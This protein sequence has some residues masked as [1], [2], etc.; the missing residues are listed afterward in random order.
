MTLQQA[1]FFG[2]LI[3]AFGLLIA[4]RIRVDVLAILL[5]LAL[6]LSRILKPEEALSGFA[7]EPA[8]VI[9]AVFVLSAGLYRT[10]LSEMMA[11]LIARMA[12]QSSVRMLAVMMPIVALMSAFTHHVTIT[13]VMLPV[14]LS[15]AKRS[16]LPP[17]KLLMPLA[18][19]SSFGTTITVLA[20]PSF[21]IASQ[22]LRQAGRP[23]LSVFS[24]APLGLAI[25]VAGTLYMLFVGRF[26]LP[27]R[28]GAEDSDQRFRLDEYFT[29]L[30]VLP[31]SPLLGKTIDEVQAGRGYDFAVVGRRREGEWLHG[32]LREQPLEAGELLL[33]RATP[34]DLLAIRQEKGV[35]LEPIVQYGE[36]HDESNS[37][38]QPDVEDSMVQVVV[39]PQSGLVGRTL[40]E[41]DFRRRYEAVVLGLWRRQSFVPEELAMTPLQAGDVLVLQ[42]ESEA[43]Q[44][45]ADDADFLMMVP[46]QGEA[47]RPRKAILAGLMMA[48]TVALAASQVVSL[49]I[50]ALSGAIAMVV[51]GC[52]TP[53]QAYKAID[54]RMYLFIAGA[55]P[56]GT[57][58]QK[59]GAAELLAGWMKVGMAGWQ[60]SLTLF[61]IFMAVGVIVQFMGSDSATVALFAPVAI[62]FGAALNAPPEPFVIAVTMAAIVA[63]LTPMSHHNLIIYGPGGYKFFDYTR[64]GAPLTVLIGVLV[65]FMAPLLFR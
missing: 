45:L 21:L 36:H 11:E 54:Q 44:G 12:G 37:H 24:P 55:I 56:L 61:V 34:D 41:V 32:F 8:I 25:T 22:L 62:A 9:A 48:G 6:A 46:F 58:M 53:N 57:A 19:G 23:G 4:E 65:A 43:L 63:T 51:S 5:I 33:V 42:G 16:D 2:I 49:G 59:T 14:A 29:E 50:A 27:D 40:S 31:E 60:E 35:E 7:S 3:V 13:A 15:L 28:Q 26:L 17:S 1:I 10:G 39:A 47:R 38:E 52:V 64:V 20:A 18:F 30:R